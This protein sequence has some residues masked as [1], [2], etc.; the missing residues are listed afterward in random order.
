M[1][2]SPIRPQPAW[3]PPLPQVLKSEAQSNDPS[4][5]LSIESTGHI[6]IS[7]D[8]SNNGIAAS[9]A[10]LSF[11]GQAV[12]VPLSGGM[13]PYQ[14]YEALAA[15]MPDGYKLRFVHEAGKDVLL[16]VIS[17]TR[18]VT[19]PQQPATPTPTPPEPP[20]GFN[21]APVQPNRP[22]PW[23]PPLPQ[24]LTAEVSSNDPAQRISHDSTGQLR[25]AGLA[26]NNGIAPSQISLSFDGQAVN[27][28]LSG[29]MTPYQTYQALEAAMPEGYKLN[30]VF[31]AGNHSHADVLVEV[32]KLG[33]SR[34]A[35]GDWLR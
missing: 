22:G 12:S 27:V 21:P 28:P 11:D 18:S 33:A 2:V 30:F 1:P 24:L 26:A 6:R 9:T 16:E 29:G 8:A 23:M 19:G 13:T 7:G 17:T 4:Q 15:A 20:D 25:I 35:D 5:R 3:M 14:T 10:S 34:P 31:Q 32:Q